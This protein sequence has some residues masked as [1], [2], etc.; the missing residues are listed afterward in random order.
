MTARIYLSAGEP[1]G[2][3]HGAGVAAAI[4]ALAPDAALEGMGGPHMEAAGVR[5]VEG[6]GRLGAIGL[7]EAAASLPS[8]LMAL[9]RARR[10]LGTA[11]YDAAVL[12][13]YPGFH[14]R[15][16]SAAARHGVPV[17]YFIPPQLWAWGAGR[18]ARLREAGVTVAAI[19]PFEQEYFESLHVVTRFVGHPLLDRASPPDR[20][21]GR[22]RLGLG[23]HTPVL[24]LAP[25]S[26][27]AE[28][29]RL[30][31]ILAAA[32]RHLRTTVP[33]LEI[34]LAATGDHTYPESGDL[35]VRWNDT[36]AVLAAADAA[37]CKSGTATL[38]AALVDTPLV[39]VYAMHPLTFAVARRVVHT[40]HVALVN[41]VAGREVAPEYLQDRATPERLAA[42]IAPLLAADREPARLQRA[43]FADVRARLGTPGASRRVAEMALELAA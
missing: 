3:L 18:A 19:L 1:S 31:P 15:L 14:L 9:H 16:L 10:R 41:L 12:I 23:T 34:V 38:E 21:A 7:V 37:L 35:I 33:D 26:R 32:A 30:W 8:H 6:I 27:P 22:G 28:V 40:P 2:D 13:D 17:L 43:G 24:A 20:A 36:P 25:G 29:R 39:V 42:A 5:L 4:R 11:C